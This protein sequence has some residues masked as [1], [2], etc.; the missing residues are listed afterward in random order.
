[1]DEMIDALS[2][3]N[4]HARAWGFGKKAIYAYKTF[5]ACAL[6][7]EIRCIQV[8]AKCHHCNG[9]GIYRDWDG[10]ARG[11]CYRCTKGIV[12]LRFIESRIGDC[13]WHHPCA[14]DAG[15]WNVL[16]AVWGI[17]SVSYKDDAYPHGVATLADGTERPIIYQQA[18]GWGPNMPG[19]E[20][21]PADEACRLLNIVEA[22][23]PDICCGNR[24]MHTRWPREKAL[25]EMSRYTIDLCS[26]RKS[27]TEC[28]VC[29]SADIYS[30]CGGLGSKWRLGHASFSRPMCATCH[31]VAPGPYHWPTEPH[32]ASLTPGVLAWLAHPER[33]RKRVVE[34]EYA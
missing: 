24:T 30:W 9:T 10:Y 11:T 25:R 27:E 31:G 5:V 7:E 20:K 6:A 2:R 29:G 19:A 16:N 33:Q 17:Q 28:C 13:R 3:L 1:M 18:E 22:A 15:G 34:R 23:L 12:T 32:P 21:L 26:D 14:N 8:Q 4:A